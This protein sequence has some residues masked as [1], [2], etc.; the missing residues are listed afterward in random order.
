MRGFG[1]LCLLM[2]AGLSWSGC[3]SVTYS[4][5]VKGEEPKMAVVQ[6]ENLDVLASAKVEPQSRGTRGAE[7]IL[8]KGVSLAVTGIKNLINADKKKYSVEYEG[9]LNELYFYNNISVNPDGVLDPSGIQFKGFEFARTVEPDGKRIKKDTA[10]YVRFEIDSDDPYEIINNSLFRLKL[11]DLKVNYAKAKVPR[12]EWYVPW[13]WF[14]KNGENINMD[15]D[16]SIMAT[17]FS[18]DGTFYENVPI[19]KF[20]FTVRDLP[21]DPG[22]QREFL[23]SAKSPIGK[24]GSGYSVLVPRS[25]SSYVSGAT[26]GKPEYV[27][28]YGKG[29]YRIDINVKEASKQS[30]L[31]KSFYDHSDEFVDQGAKMIK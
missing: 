11:V 1:I 3:T 19:G 31:M 14:T 21:L 9:V 4:N 28:A 8:G 24:R 26:R 10:M 15:F 12:K 23:A 6:D 25:F 5:A 27:S 17:W 29:I 30:F 18:R 16:I 13:T 22:K 7:E 20:N 2:W